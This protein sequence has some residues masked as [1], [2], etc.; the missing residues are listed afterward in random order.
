MRTR[1]AILTILAGFAGGC[2]S[3]RPDVHAQKDATEV[4]TKHW[5]GTTGV[6]KSYRL[7][8]KSTPAK[9]PADT[10]ASKAGS[11]AKGETK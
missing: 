10:S 2:S 5:S 1:L 11:G 7:P 6:L 3:N 8:A 9:T 4:N